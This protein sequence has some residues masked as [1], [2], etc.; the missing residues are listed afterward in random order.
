MYPVGRKARPCMKSTTSFYMA[1]FN[2]LCP[3]MS[4]IANL[5]ER[6]LKSITDYYVPKE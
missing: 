5:E 4:I 6:V 3:K 2:V 1:M